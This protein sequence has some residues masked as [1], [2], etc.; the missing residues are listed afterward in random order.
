MDYMLDREAMAVGEVIFD[1]CQEQPVD[2]NISLPDYCPDIQRILKCQ[3]YPKIGSRSVSGDRLI[4]EGGF[5]VKVFYLDPEGTRIRFCDSTDTFSAEIALKQTAE[6]AKIEAFPRVEYI[7][8]RATSPRR[9]DIHGAFS[10]CAKVTAQGRSE[11]VSN[12]V[13]SD[14]E[15][16]KK[17]M[18]VNNLAGFC[19]Q[20]FSVDEILELGDGKPSADSILRTDAFAVLQDF[21]VSAGKLMIKGEVCVK[22]L[23]DG[24]DENSSEPEAVEFTIPF[25]QMLDCTGVTENSLCDIRLEVVGIDAQ[26]K[27][28]YS[29]DKTFF[30]TQIHLFAS[31]AVYQEA[32]VTLV[33]DAYS[34]E[35]DLNVESKQKTVE[36]LAELVGDTTVQESTLTVE[37]GTISKVIDIWNE[38]GSVSTEI[39]DGQVIFKGKYN[40]CILALNEENKPFYFERLLEFE[41]PHACNSAGDNLKCDAQI[42]VGGISFRLMGGGIEAKAELRLTAEIYNRITFKAIAGVTADEE[43]PVARDNAAAL[44]LYYAEAGENLW[45]IAR[46]YR[47]SMD[48]IKQENGMEGDAMEKKGMLLIPM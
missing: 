38:M 6:N 40:L 42:G 12:I 28:D 2:L 43:K 24:T 30:D 46:N 16:Q 11:V 39:K 21:K 34:K 8:C 25:N 1:G 14:V 9:L 7:N 47:T 29:G 10:V 18:K 48:A 20:Q 35:Y 33:G 19:Q 23:Y 36:N 37:D 5:T 15:Q 45:D 17:T 31:A 3:I 44:C 13:G 27:N 22:F 41:H 26:I 32:E 4:L